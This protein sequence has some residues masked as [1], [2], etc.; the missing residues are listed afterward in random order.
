MSKIIN[1]KA[2]DGYILEIELDSHHK[3]IYDM[4][5]RLHGV[6]FCALSEL[7]RFKSFHIENG[8]TL[9]WD[10]LCQISIDEIINNME[11]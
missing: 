8:N 11:R 3:I 9:V 4:K 5:P 7:S 2:N 6:R 10:R 1:A